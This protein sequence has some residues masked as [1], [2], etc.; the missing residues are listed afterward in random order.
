MEK[1]IYQYPKT[2]VHEVRS[3]YLMSTPGISGTGSGT[4]TSGQGAWG[5]GSGLGSTINP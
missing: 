3:A 1:K 4:S 2:E 5:G